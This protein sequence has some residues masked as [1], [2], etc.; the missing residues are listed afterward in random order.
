[1]PNLGEE[2]CGEYLKYVCKC[3]FVAYNVTNPDAHGEIDV[4]AINLDEML[5]YVCEVAIHTSGLQY[6]KDKKPDDYNRFVAKFDKDIRYA[7]KYFPNYKV[8]PMLWSPIVKISGKSAKYNTLVELEKVVQYVDRIHSLH[9]EL[10]IN[11]KFLSAITA[12][13][14]H[15][16]QETSEF[17]SNVMRMFQIEGTLRKHLDK[18]GRHASK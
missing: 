16:D 13:R 1:M 7:Q 10:T 9:L 12:L 15:S 4:I 8:R 17:K 6:V 3:E 5:I 14:N 18:L 2:I 11:N